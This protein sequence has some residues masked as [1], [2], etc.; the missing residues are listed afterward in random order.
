MNLVAKLD[1]HADL[2]NRMSE[3]RNVDLADAVLHGTVDAQTL[4]SSVFRC[5]Q[6]EEADQCEHWLDEA[7]QGETPKP[8]GCRNKTLL[9]R[10]AR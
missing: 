9:D 4:R 3:A 5:M 1:R 6:C 2:F 10:L 7:G 8:T